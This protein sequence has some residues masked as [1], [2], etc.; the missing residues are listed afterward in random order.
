MRGPWKELFTSKVEAPVRWDRWD[1]LASVVG[2]FT[3]LWVFALKLKAFYDLGYS[4]DL[5][6]QVQ[7]ARSWLEGRGLLQDN[8]SGNVLATHTHF[9][10]VPLGL[11][12]KPF[13]APGLL[14]VLA[15]FVGATYF[16]AARVLRLL[17]VAGPVAVI[18]AAVLLAAPLS[19]AFYQELGF[20]FHVEILAPTLC[21]VLFY[22][23][24]QQRMIPSIVTALAVISVKE[25][26]PIGATV[27]AIVAGVETWISSREKRARYRFNWPAAITILLSVCAVPLLLAISCSQPPT[28]YV[29]HSVDRLGIVAPGSL[30]SPGA[31]FGFVAANIPH[32]LSSDVVRRWLWIMIVGSFGTILLRPY[33]LVVG[34]PTTAV[35]WLMNRNDLLWAPRFSSAEALLLCITLVGFASIAHAAQSCSKWTRTAVLTTTIAIVALSASAQ[36]VLV[37]HVYWAYRLR[38]VSF[39]SPQDRQEAD[40]VFAHYRREGKPEEPVI[41][42]TFLF[43]YAHDR[44]LFW[45]D[46]LRGRPAP[47]WILGDSADPYVRFRISADMIDSASGIKMED[48]TVIDRRGRFVLLKRKDGRQREDKATRVDTS[49][50][51]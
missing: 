37:P 36:L 31:L 17:G 34:V 1:L 2:V 13:G 42:S 12:A 26:A 43:R 20:G 23:L 11:I 21:L 30:S 49:L 15:A 4:S 18:A 51:P 10:L 22:F 48:Y 24:L 44:N 45:L 38:P 25:D 6:M 39:Y 41:A 14:F 16:W 35:A 32:W 7:N 9:L 46:R 8:F 29:R 47:I 27:V 19:V 3:V 5:F 28:M 50:S 33:Y 40:A